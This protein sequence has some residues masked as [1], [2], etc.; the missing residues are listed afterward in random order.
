[1]GRV[2]RLGRRVSA[3]CVIVAYPG[4]RYIESL[5]EVQAS[6]D[7]ETF[8]PPSQVKE[9]QKWLGDAKGRPTWLE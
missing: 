6:L 3:A 5:F 8:N 7:S 4:Y 1:V 2:L 9:S